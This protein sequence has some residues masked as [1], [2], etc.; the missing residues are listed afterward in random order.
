[1][2]VASF[3]LNLL[4]A[5][6]ALYAERNVTRAASRLGLAQPSMSNALARMRALFDD[7]LFVKTPQGMVPTERAEALA[8]KVDAAL[9]LV[10]EALDA[11]APFDP[12]SARGTITLAA[13][14]NVVLGL[15]PALACRVEEVAPGLD[16]RFGGF[17]KDVVMGALD[18]GEADLAIGRFAEIPARFHQRVA[19]RDRFVVIARADH[20]LA[21]EGL[22]LDGFC[23]ATHILVS[24]RH[25]GRGAV[26][27]ALAALGRSRRVGLVLAQFAV[28]PDIVA[29]TDH[30]ATIPE[31]VAGALAA[32]AGCAIHP[33][34]LAVDPWQMRMIWSAVANA[35][36]ATRFVIDTIE[37]MGRGR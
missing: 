8:P 9:A 32:R 6:A 29:R 22:S 11:P 12:A 2:N 27:S 35:D 30:I 4:K 20:A 31:S 13:P 3:D 26:D 16:L 21:A 7:A 10:A 33:L 18:R 28:V 5:F 37:A 14:D 19:G 23:A 36:P 1:M 25:D 17:N 15:A 34:P 24:F